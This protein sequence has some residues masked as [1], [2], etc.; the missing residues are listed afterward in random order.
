MLEP[1]IPH[2]TCFIYHKNNLEGLER[3]IK[4][5]DNSSYLAKDLFIVDDCSKDGT[6]VSSFIR[7]KLLEGIPGKININVSEIGI[8]NSLKRY[9]QRYKASYTNYVLVL[10]SNC[11][12]DPECLIKLSDF[13]H[14]LV[15][16]TKF[17]VNGKE[18]FIDYPYGMLIRNFE[19][20][21]IEPVENEGTIYYHKEPSKLAKMLK[22]K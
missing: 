18:K 12:L 15:Q 16:R 3:T 10:D 2:I 13:A 9:F 4:S 6:K 1:K 11:M 14:M 19:D 5:I 21:Y 20:I 7:K 17:N 8:T 22:I